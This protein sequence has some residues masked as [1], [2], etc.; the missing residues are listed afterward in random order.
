MHTP[1]PGLLVQL[2]LDLLQ[3]CCQPI[4]LSI[5]GL[6]VAAQ[7]RQV[8]HGRLALVTQLLALLLQEKD[9]TTIMHMV[10]TAA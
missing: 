7:P 10:S 9:T 5:A 6:A 8:T 2:V 4:P 3:L 1:I